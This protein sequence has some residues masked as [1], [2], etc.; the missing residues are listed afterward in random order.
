M[1]QKTAKIINKY[2]KLKNISKKLLKKEWMALDESKKDLKRQE[3]IS[4]LVKK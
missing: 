4:Q 3:M 2:S 1:N